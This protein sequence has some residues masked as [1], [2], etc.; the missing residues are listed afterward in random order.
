M[1]KLLKIVYGVLIHGTPFAATSARAWR[2][3][4]HLPLR[5]ARLARAFAEWYQA[6]VL[7][8]R[9]DCDELGAVEWCGRSGVAKLK[10][11]A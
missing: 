9:N 4:Q 3:T 5:G 10:A 7:A 8:H 2:A 11:A 1:A 6:L